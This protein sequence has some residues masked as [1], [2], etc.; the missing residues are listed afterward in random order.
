MEYIDWAVA[1]KFDV[2]DINV[3]A[4]ITR[5]EVCSCDS[6]PLREDEDPD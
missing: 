6:C 3:P 2:M 5:D 1:H 4:Y